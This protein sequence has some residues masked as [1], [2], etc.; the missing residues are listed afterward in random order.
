MAE[1]RHPDNAEYNLG[2]RRSGEL[3]GRGAWRP[4]PQL[5]PQI[6]TNRPRGMGRG[7]RAPWGCLRLRPFGYSPTSSLYS[8]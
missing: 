4:D 5:F 6:Y 3:C 2:E 8:L 1:D 7:L